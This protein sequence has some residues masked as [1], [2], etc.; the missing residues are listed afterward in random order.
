MRQ[1]IEII[2]S[3]MLDITVIAVSLFLMFTILSFGCSIAAQDPNGPTVIQR[4]LDQCKLDLQV[5]RE[6]K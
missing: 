2:T 1:K 6:G 5:C 4:Q 3:T